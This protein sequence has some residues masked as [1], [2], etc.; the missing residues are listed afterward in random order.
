MDGYI[1]RVTGMARLIP[2]HIWVVTTPIPNE[3]SCL[4]DTTKHEN[5]CYFQDSPD[6]SKKDG[7]GC[8]T[9]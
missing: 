2:H 6:V 8:K 4:L 3:T 5:A 9:W 7:N 1:Q